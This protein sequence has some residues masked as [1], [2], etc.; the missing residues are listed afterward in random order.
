MP[1]PTLTITTV[2]GATWNVPEEPYPETV[3]ASLFTQGVDPEDARAERLR[4]ELELL[5]GVVWA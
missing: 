4:L 3:T 5:D 2:T 1:T